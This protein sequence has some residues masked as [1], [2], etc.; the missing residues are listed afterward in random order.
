MSIL[1]Y[2]KSLIKNT[3]RGKHNNQRPPPP[4]QFV[5]QKVKTTHQQ[6]KRSF[7]CCQI[8]TCI[9]NLPNIYFLIFVG[10]YKKNICK[11]FVIGFFHFQNFKNS[12]LT[13]FGLYSHFKFLR[14]LTCDCLFGTKRYTVSP[15]KFF[16]F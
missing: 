2:G 10:L 5:L 12:L 6:A 3:K 1:I 15:N 9:T 8:T 4:Q 13:L 16:T 11:F 14:I 7:N